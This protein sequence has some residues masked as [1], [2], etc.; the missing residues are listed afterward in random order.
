MNYFFFSKKRGGFGPTDTNMFGGGGRDR[1]M[2][3]LDF[4]AQPQLS[5][6]YE[7]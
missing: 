7:W 5:T 4:N 1:M 3:A 6:T 2:T